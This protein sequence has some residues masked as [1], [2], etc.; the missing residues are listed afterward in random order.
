M[1]ARNDPTRLEPESTSTPPGTGRRAFLLR[2]S[3]GIAVA[4]TAA[5]AG[6]AWAAGPTGAD[7]N[8]VKLPLI[9]DPNTEQKEETPD[10]SLPP[11]DRIGYA[12]VGLGRLS[13]N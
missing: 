12:I 6:N 8:Q 13:L 7:A 9:Q 3:A 4:F 5:S 1:P 10:A 11:D 2:G